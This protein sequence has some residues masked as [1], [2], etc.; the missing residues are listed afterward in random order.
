MDEVASNEVI[1]VVGKD[2]YI[3]IPA[4]SIYGEGKTI[5]CKLNWLLH[6]VGDYWQCGYDYADDYPHDQ[7]GGIYLLRKDAEKGMVPMF[8]VMFSSSAEEANLT[9]LLKATTKEEANET[10]HKDGTAKQH[11]SSKSNR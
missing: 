5:Q 6:L 2:L 1:N 4:P 9:E 11:R 3:Y 8:N 7:G 10:V